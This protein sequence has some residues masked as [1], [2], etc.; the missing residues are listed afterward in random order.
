MLLGSAVKGTCV[1]WVVGPKVTWIDEETGGGSPVGSAPT[2]SGCSGSEKL[3]VILVEG[4]TPLSPKLGVVTGTLLGG[5]VSE[6]SGGSSSSPTVE[7]ATTCVLSTLPP[8][9]RTAVVACRRIWRLVGKVS[10]VFR[11]P[12]LSAT[13]TNVRSESSLGPLE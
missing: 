1:I 3:I 5:A 8:W 11:S 9:K 7:L 13:N 2:L 10:C 4:S 12:S 6:T